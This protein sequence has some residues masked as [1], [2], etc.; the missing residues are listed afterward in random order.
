MVFIPIEAHLLFLYQFK[1]VQEAYEILSDSD[2]R[3]MY[4]RFGMDAVKND[5]GSSG[6]GGFPFG[7]V[8]ESLFSQ[9]LGGDLFGGCEYNNMKSVVIW[10]VAR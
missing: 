4:D 9:F 8:S 5:G 2:K 3:G 10:E 7:G 6:M 1:E